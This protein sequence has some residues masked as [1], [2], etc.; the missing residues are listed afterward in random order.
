MSILREAFIANHVWRSALGHM[1]GPK[2]DI[3]RGAFIK[4]QLFK[5]LSEAIWR[6]LKVVFYMK[7]S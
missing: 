6:G 1:A 4:C 7:H 3:S 2:V 5:D